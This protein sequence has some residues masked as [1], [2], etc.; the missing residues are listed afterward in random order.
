MILFGIYLYYNNKSYRYQDWHILSHLWY[1]GPEF[2]KINQA[3]ETGIVQTNLGFIHHYWVPLSPRQPPPPFRLP[4]IVYIQGKTLAQPPGLT[5]ISNFVSPKYPK[6]CFV[7]KSD[8][9]FCRKS[10]EITETSEKVT[11]NF[12]CNTALWVL[13]LCRMEFGSRIYHYFF[14]QLP[15]KSEN[16]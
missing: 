10:L 14:D 5:W 3:S 1:L 4:I 2:D 12:V 16:N 11:N 15:Y 9:R 6:C 13:K 7:S 8:S